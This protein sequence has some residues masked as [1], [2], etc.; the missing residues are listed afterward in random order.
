MNDVVGEWLRGHTSLSPTLEIR[1]L[2]VSMLRGSRRRAVLKGVDLQV[3]SG[4]IT[5]LVG[6]SG[7]GKTTL[8]HVIHGLLPREN[9]PE[10]SGHISILGEEMVGAGEARLRIARKRLVRVIAQDPFDALNPT[11]SVHAQMTEVCRTVTAVKRLRWAGISDIE[12]VMASLPHQLSGGERQRVLIAMMTAVPVPLIVADEPTTGLDHENKQRVISLLQKLAAGGTAVLLGTHDLRLA[13]ISDQTAILEDGRIVEVGPTS[14][15]FTSP[16]HPYSKGL[17]AIRY[18]KIADKSA[19]LPT[20]V[21]NNGHNA[22]PPPGYHLQKSV[23]WPPFSSDRVEVV[24]EMCKISKAFRTKKLFRHTSRHVLTEIDLTVKTGECVA[25]VGESGIGKS[26]LLKI[27]AGL[28]EQ[29]G[30]TVR[31]SDERPPQLIF[32]DPKSFLTPWVPIGE[33]IVEGLRSRKITRVTRNQRL[34][35]LMDFVDLD[36]SLA[37]AF[38]SELSVGQCQR[39]AIA[40]ALAVS[41]RLILCDEPISALDTSLAASI[42]NLIGRLRRIYGTAV[43]IATHDLAAAKIAADRVYRLHDRKLHELGDTSAFSRHDSSDPF[44]EDT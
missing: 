34:N 25:L 1:D 31:R 30:G 35:E 6:R 11:M 2:H 5:A 13:E 8:S 18:D 38:P 22:N 3:R 37:K 41:P 15:T 44:V 17:L 20:L 43:I 28:L 14:T 29:D 26:T 21:H 23:P 9:E 33:L 19:Q 40:R 36:R 10:I 32:Q 7:S 39:A 27:A 42:L 4:E 24:L 12:R 16:H